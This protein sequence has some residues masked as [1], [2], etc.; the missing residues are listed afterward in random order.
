MTT[1]ITVN[2]GGDTTVTPPS[3]S[4]TITVANDATAV[5]AE[6]PSGGADGYILAK[7]SAADFDAEWVPNSSDPALPSRVSV[8]EYDV[9]ELRDTVAVVEASVSSAEAD[10]VA[11][12][13]RS[14]VTEY[15]VSE[16]IDRIAETEADIVRHEYAITDAKITIFNGSDVTLNAEE[17]IHQ[18][19]IISSLITSEVRTLNL[20]SN[21][22]CPCILGFF[23]FHNVPVSIH[24]SGNEGGTISL[25]A[26]KL[27]I[28]A[29]GYGIG[30]IRLDTH[31]DEVT[32]MLSRIS[33]S[34]YDIA[35]LGDS[36]ISLL[37][38]TSLAESDIDTLQSRASVIEYDIAEMRDMIDEYGAKMIVRS[39]TSDNTLTFV[40]TS[41]YY[42]IFPSS[43]PAMNVEAGETYRL[44]MT[45]RGTNGAT[46]T[47]KAFAINGGTCTF[48]QVGY[49]TVSRNVAVNTISGTLATNFINVATG[50]TVVANASAVDWQFTVDGLITINAAGTFVPTIAFTTADPTGTILMKSGNT[51]CRLTKVNNFN[52]A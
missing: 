16:A 12:Q 52:H 5:V 37:S 2:N 42:P 23:N 50:Q 9:A 21:G 26:L 29:Y 24:F 4:M 1:V 41:T 17:S 45:V 51:F 34:E 6:L 39:L 22:K 19:H 30:A 38:R 31:D 18:M 43:L 7:A 40:N 14:S 32:S 8:V 11:L 46:S 13:G 10:I 25:P 36:I 35:E 15:N 3:A 49:S 48:T 28:V 27:S 47:A 44:E 20:T 33:V